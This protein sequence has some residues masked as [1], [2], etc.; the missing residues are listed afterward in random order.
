M[1]KLFPFLV[2]FAVLSFTA[3]NND[4][5]ADKSDAKT[6]QKVDDAT[7]TQSTK[8]ASFVAKAHVCGADCKDGSHAYSHGE[9]GHTCTADC[10][11][12][13]TCTAAC[14]EGNH[15]YAHGEAGHTCTDECA[16]M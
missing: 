11:M 16:R 8:T 7:T 3:C 13:H 14:K 10:G 6:D 5:K 12:A 15:T 2:L 9:I 1:K 4:K